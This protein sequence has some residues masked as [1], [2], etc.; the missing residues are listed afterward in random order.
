MV[1]GLLNGDGLPLKASTTM[2]C[3]VIWPLFKT[4]G[5]WIEKS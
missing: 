1:T 4:R 2:T 5:N 3:S